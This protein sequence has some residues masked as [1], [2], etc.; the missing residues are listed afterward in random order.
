MSS[1]KAKPT[2]LREPVSYSPPET[3]APADRKIDPAEF[4]AWLEE[5]LV[6]FSGHWTR[7][8]TGR[9]KS[10]LS[11]T[12]EMLQDFV[13]LLV[14]FLPP[15]LGPYRDQVE[16]LWAEASELYGATAARRGRAS[17][18]VVEEFQILREVVIRALYQD[19][20]LGGLVPLSL[21]EVLRLNRAIDRGVTHASVGHTDAL[22]HSL[23][24]GGGIPDMPSTSDLVTEVHAR[25]GA[26]EEGLREVLGSLPGEQGD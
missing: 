7:E 18:E 2:T 23:L 22:F 24:E 17:G 9:G 11:S 4:C 1:Y 21:R 13:G 25:L 5:R 15:L 8:L 12:E 3:S 19:P 26:I 10:P 20:P 16:P 6:V 14:R